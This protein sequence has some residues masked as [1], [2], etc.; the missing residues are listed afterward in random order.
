M[1]YAVRLSRSDTSILCSGYLNPL[2][3]RISTLSSHTIGTSVADILQCNPLPLQSVR[4]LRIGPSRRLVR[5]TV[6]TRT[7]GIAN[8]SRHTDPTVGVLVW[9]DE[10]GRTVEACSGSI[11]RATKLW[12]RYWGVVVFFSLDGHAAGVVEAGCT[13]FFGNRRFNVGVKSK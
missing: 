3:F 7:H 10:V 11:C 12:L 13:L 6:S 5:A 1:T 4:D 9:I 2:P 8:A